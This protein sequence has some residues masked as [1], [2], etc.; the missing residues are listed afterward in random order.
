M[1][2]SQKV[3]RR[4]HDRIKEEEDMKDR[5]EE[6]QQLVL[7]SVDLSK[8]ISDTELL[9]MIDTIL[10][11]KSQEMYISL[12]ERHN[13]RKEIFNSIRKL[14]ILQDLIDDREIS[15]IM[16]N[17]T[18]TIFI[19][20]K[21]L[22]HPCEKHFS[23]KKK[24]EDL[25]QQ[26]VSQSNRMINEASPIVDARLSDGSRVNIVL[27]PIAIDGPV[28]TIRKFPEKPITIEQLIDMGAISKKASEFLEK[29]VIAGYNIFISGG[30]GSGKT[31]FLNVLSN[32]IPPSE[33]IITIEDSAELQIRNI[34][35]LVRLEV[36]NANTEGNNQITIRDLIKTSLRM[37]P[38]RIIVG[39]VRDEAAIDMLQALNTGHDGSLSTGHANSPRD[40]LSRLE[41]L[42]LLAADI[43]LLAIRKQIASALDIIVHLGRL[44]DRSR[45]VLAIMEV[46]DCVEGEIQMNELFSFQERGEEDGRIQGELTP[47]HELIQ[48]DKLIR[49]GIM[50]TNGGDFYHSGL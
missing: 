35:N 9:G 33:R 8:E 16:V 17:G 27:P 25:I 24:L 32:F 38:S 5:K 21:G 47:K 49:A 18:D 36:R 40:M 31:T 14:D 12:S 34:P 28:I 20:K 45:R 37:R 13:L 2:V 46:L 11:R 30:T 7:E 4:S 6:I 48:K 15:E 1:D 39:E 10:L 26:I 23:S 29:L 42:V 50:T 41:A 3:S 44:R 43:P 22:I 19:E